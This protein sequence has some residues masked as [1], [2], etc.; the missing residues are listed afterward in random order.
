MI[1]RMAMRMPMRMP[2]TLAMAFRLMGL[3]RGLLGMAVLHRSVTS[4][5]VWLWLCGGRFASTARVYM[6][7][8]VHDA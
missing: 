4:I 5:G 6:W 8:L 1:V 7:V 3:L 2:T